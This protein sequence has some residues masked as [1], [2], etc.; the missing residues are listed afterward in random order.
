MSIRT[1]ASDDKDFIDSLF[2]RTLLEEAIDFII[3]RYSPGEI[4]DK[5]LLEEWALDSGFVREAKVEE[6]E[7]EV[8]ELE[9]EL[10]QVREALKHFTDNL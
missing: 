5:E 2:S 8:D 1:T 6:L 4:Y 7:D 9:T 3:N 10:E